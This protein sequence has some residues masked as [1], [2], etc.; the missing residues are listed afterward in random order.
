MS[1]RYFIHSTSGAEDPNLTNGKIFAI[2]AEA[3]ELINYGADTDS[4]TKADALFFVLR[5]AEQNTVFIISESLV[6]Y[7]SSETLED[8]PEEE[9]EEESE[10]SDEDEDSEG[11]DEEAES[12]YAAYSI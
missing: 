9:S 4:E 2:E 10:D 1:R 6:E 11:K 3:C 8:Y 7:M 5:D 12:A